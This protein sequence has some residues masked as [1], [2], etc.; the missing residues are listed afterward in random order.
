MP[1]TDN[2]DSAPNPVIGHPHAAKNPA[3]AED[4]MNSLLFIVIL[5]ILVKN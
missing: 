1:A 4:F 5:F 3:S 2:P